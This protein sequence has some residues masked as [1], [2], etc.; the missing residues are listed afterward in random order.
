MAL[1]ISAEAAPD[2]RTVVSP[3]LADAVDCSDILRAVDLRS[4]Q[5]QA[6]PNVPVDLDEV[7]PMTKRFILAHERGEPGQLSLLVEGLEALDP[8]KVD[9]CRESLR[10]GTDGPVHPLYCNAYVMLADGE[11]EFGHH[12]FEQELRELA[13]GR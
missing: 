2:N 8:V 11:L 5:D 12:Y 1:G 13:G 3:P 9:E 4:C 10:T 7:D 6:Y